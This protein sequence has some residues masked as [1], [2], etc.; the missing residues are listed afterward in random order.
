MRK[1][2]QLSSRSIDPSFNTFS[3]SH[4]MS[5]QPQTFLAQLV[6]DCLWLSIQILIASFVIQ[7]RRLTPKHYFNICVFA[8]TLHPFWSSAN[9][10]SHKLNFFLSH[11]RNG[12]RLVSFSI[13]VVAKFLRRTEIQRTFAIFESLLKTSLREIKTKNQLEQTVD[14]T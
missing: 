4:D 8:T 3:S 10:L 1:S 5:K 11:K 12:Y 6:F 7:S 13:L 14:K 2:Q 9:I